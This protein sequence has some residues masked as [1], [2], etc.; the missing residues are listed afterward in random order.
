MPRSFLDKLD[1]AISL[2]SEEPLTGG[3]GA[4]P[5]EPTKAG[6]TKPG[7]APS[8]VAAEKQKDEIEIGKQQQNSSSAQTKADQLYKA[9]QK[10]KTECDKD[11]KAA[12]AKRDVA[13]FNRAASTRKR[14]EQAYQAYQLAQT[15]AMG[16]TGN[17]AKAS[18]LPFDA[19]PH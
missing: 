5:P 14:M 4:P 12:V 1:Q 18:G 17:P 8:G 6:T 13:L 3:G 7:A 11:E 10:V 16:Q 2:L 15:Q 9:Y 19:A